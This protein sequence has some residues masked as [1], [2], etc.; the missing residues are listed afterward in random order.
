MIFDPATPIDDN[1]LRF[2]KEVK[3]ISRKNPHLQWVK[4]RQI[5]MISFPEWFVSDVSV[6]YDWMR[7]EKFE[8][9]VK[10]PINEY[11]NFADGM[12]FD[13]HKK[14]CSFLQLMNFLEKDVSVEIVKFL[15]F[16]CREVDLKQAIQE[17]PH[18]PSIEISLSE[19]QILKIDPKHRGRITARR[20]G[21]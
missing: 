21:L 12:T 16:R 6:I 20:F 2:V 19:M 4:D 8:I 15:A 10:N 5:W 14:T 17:L 7:Y 1:L 11:L 18:E 9:Y 3:R 13:S